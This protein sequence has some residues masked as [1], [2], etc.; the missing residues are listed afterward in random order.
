[1]SD[2]KR[3]G[4]VGPTGRR[5]EQPSLDPTHIGS[6]GPL[7]RADEASLRLALPNLREIPLSPRG[8]H[9]WFAKRLRRLAL[10]TSD[11]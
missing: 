5:L 8:M 1:M 3:W 7:R 4:E 2:D 11:A 10:R 6:L 9:E